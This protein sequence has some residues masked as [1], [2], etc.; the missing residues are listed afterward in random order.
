MRLLL[1][2]A[3]LLSACGATTPSLRVVTMDGLDAASGTTL[4]TINLWDNYQTRAHITGR[5]HHGETAT[6]LRQD[7][8]GC[9]VRTA[10]GA[11]GWVTCANFVREFKH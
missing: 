9:E 5:A 4:P 7:G 8:A 1:L 6:L 3:L 2:A 10:S 11:Q